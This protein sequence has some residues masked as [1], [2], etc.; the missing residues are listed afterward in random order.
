MAGAVD[1]ETEGD[2]DAWTKVTV[3]DHES[4]SA[5][6][7]AACG[8]S[9]FHASFMRVGAFPG[10]WSTIA[11]RHDR[12]ALMVLQSLAASY[13]VTHGTSPNTCFTKRTSI[14]VAGRPPIVVV[15]TPETTAVPCGRLRHSA[16][17]WSYVGSC[18]S[19]ATLAGYA[20]FAVKK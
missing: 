15:V 9:V 3:A 13:G 4:N 12:P 16:T 10:P 7:S 1:A 8:L 20:C 6:N 11:S 17:Y 2:A 5:A 19:V 14:T 18:T